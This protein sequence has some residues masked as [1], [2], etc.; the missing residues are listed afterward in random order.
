MLF[1]QINLYTNFNFL[2]ILFRRD[3]NSGGVAKIA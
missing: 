3:V 2:P 1:R